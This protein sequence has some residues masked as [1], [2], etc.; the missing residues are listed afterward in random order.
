M[1][2]IDLH[3]HSTASDG[4][5]TPEALVQKAAALGLTVI[6][7]ADHDTVD[8][9]DL[10]IAA[11]K[12]FPRLKIIPAIEISTETPTGEVHILG[13]FIDHTSEELKTTLNQFRNS[14]EIR[15]RRMVDKLKNKGVNIS[16]E[17]V[18]EIAGS[19]SIGRP[20][21]AQAMLEKGYISSLAEAFEK[22]IGHGGP[23]YVERDKMTPAEAVKLVIQTD[24]LAML[25][26]PS[27]VSNVE[28]LVI[29]LK[30]AG[31]AGIEAY[32]KDYTNEQI[33]GWVN[34]ATRHNLIVT[35]GSDY[36]GLDDTTEVMI[37]GTPVPQECVE[38]LVALAWERKVKSICQPENL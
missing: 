9:V 23:A 1:S 18:R 36:H 22:Y 8:G 28:S 12:A 2:R 11:A 33:E 20:H 17:R 27:T 26:H 25:A 29:E 10:A 24:G 35:G 4:L 5:L 21:V 6:A 31:L 3:L 19:G 38:R 34:M 16:W 32:Y 30:A 37:G 13:Y 14:R 15:A 7:L